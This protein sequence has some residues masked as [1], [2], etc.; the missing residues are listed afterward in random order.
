[1]AWRPLRQGLHQLV[2]RLV[3]LVDSFVLKLPRYIADADA[4]FRQS[5]QQ[6][7]GFLD[8]LFEPGFRLSM[9]AVGIQRFQRR[10]VDR[11]QSAKGLDVFHVAVVRV[12]G[13]GAGPEQPL[14]TGAL[15]SQ[16]PKPFAAEDR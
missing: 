6:P 8:I 15:S 9:V 12:L 5:R 3:K 10:G 1:M 11:V 4:E 7:A 2:E 13:A 14:G 16:L